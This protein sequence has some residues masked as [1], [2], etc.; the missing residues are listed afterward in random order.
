[1]S[2]GQSCKCSA[3]EFTFH[4]GHN[5]HTGS[6]CVICRSCLARF[7]LRT[8]S[9]WGPEAAELIELQKVNEQLVYK[10]KRKPP[11]VE[12]SWEPTGEFLLAEPIEGSTLVSYPIQEIRCPSCKASGQLALDFE[13]GEVCP[14]CKHGKLV[15]TQVIY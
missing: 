3:C 10:H 5:H 1:M 13:T 4:S 2:F 14:E 15:C 6:S 12:R 11:R 7:E 9:F 8:R